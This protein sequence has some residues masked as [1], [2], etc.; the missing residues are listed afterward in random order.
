MPSVKLVQIKTTMAVLPYA[1]LD[2]PIPAGICKKPDVA[3]KKT[4]AVN[5]NGPVSAGKP[6]C[7][8]NFCRA[9]M[10]N[11]QPTVAKIAIIND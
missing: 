9:G 1:G 10:R 6:H 4:Q 3:S 5:T 11:E 7:P 8:K 2:H